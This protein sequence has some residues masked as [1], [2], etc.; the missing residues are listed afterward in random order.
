MPDPTTY[1]SKLA[2][3]AVLVIGGSSGLGFGVACALL[4]HG[5]SHVIISSSQ[6]SRVDDAIRRLE[7][8]YPDAVGRGAKLVG[9]ACNLGEPDKL[10][11]EVRQ[12][13]TGV[14]KL[15][16]GR[17][18]NHVVFTAGDG[19]A[20]KEIEEWDMPFVQ[21]A[22]SVRFFA[23]LMVAKYARKALVWDSRS[24]IT[25]TTGSVSDKPIPGWTVVASYA[26][27]LHGMVRNLALDL[28]P[29]R[30]NLVSPGPVETEM[31]DA[32]GQEKKQEMLESMAAKTTTGKVGSVEDVVE[33]Y[34]AAMK[35]RN[36]SGSVV[37]SDSGHLLV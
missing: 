20:M 36:M 28:K 7:K 32:H 4:E 17:K 8:T 26:A 2:S 1:T 33:A 9:V 34:L 12:L 6:Q 11:G 19:L 15:L 21:K 27:G 3:T 29:V 30:V 24:S 23:P 37:N 13:F 16:S 25:L 10:E 31:W 18:L 35:D 22:G 14:E 5:A